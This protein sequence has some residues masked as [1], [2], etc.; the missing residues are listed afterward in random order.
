LDPA[1]AE[2]LRQRG[3]DVATTVDAFLES[4]TDEE[5]LK[6][7]LKEERALIT[8]D[9]DVLILHSRGQKHAGIVFWECGTRSNAEVIRHLTLLADCVKAEEMKGK[10][11][12]L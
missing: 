10:V 8:N 2:G 6:F 3:I 12:F 4:A 9:G 11:E 7:A 1:V 5:Y